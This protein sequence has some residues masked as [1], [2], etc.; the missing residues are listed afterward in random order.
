MRT[1][2]RLY[3]ATGQQTLVFNPKGQSED[4]FQFSCIVFHETLHQGVPNSRTEEVVIV[5]LQTLISL[6]QLSKHPKMARADT[7]LTR[8]QHQ[9]SGEIQFRQRHQAGI[10]RVQSPGRADPPEGSVIPAT[11]WFEQFE[12]LPGFADLPGNPLL[13]KILVNIAKRGTAVPQS[14]NFDWT[15]SIRTARTFPQKS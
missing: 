6:E 9:C 3:S 4:P 11:T 13:R 2:E 15:S 5:S 14:P 12:D 8:R 7:E 1:L 10:I